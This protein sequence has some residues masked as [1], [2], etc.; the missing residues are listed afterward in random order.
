M[1]DKVRLKKYTN[2]RLYDTEKSQYVTLSQV[3]KIIKE[4]RSVEV[5]D[6]KTS[7]DVTSFILTQIVLEEAKRKKILLP[8]PA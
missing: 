3:A 8:A 7:E 1:D 4:G 5:I 6:V 2:R